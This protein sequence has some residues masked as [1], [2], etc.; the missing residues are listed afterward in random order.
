MAILPIMLKV[1]WLSEG[2]GERRLIDL[3]GFAAGKKLA[4]SLDSGPN[5]S[6][7]NKLIFDAKC[8]PILKQ[9]QH[10]IKAVKNHFS[11]TS[12]IQGGEA[13]EVQ[14]PQA[15]EKILT[16]KTQQ[17][18]IMQVTTKESSSDLFLLKIGIFRVFS[19]K[20]R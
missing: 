10:S 12:S 20:P 11:P 15:K 14:A 6:V 3:H 7:W 17:T 8:L 13:A 18:E 1:W 4:L 19:M 16:P 2:E 5:L 9:A